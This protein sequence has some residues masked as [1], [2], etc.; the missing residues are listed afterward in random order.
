MSRLVRDDAGFVA[1]GEALL[2]GVLTCVTGMLIA[3]NAWA[4]VDARGQ[5]DT[6]AR[7]AARAFVE[8]DSQSRALQDARS[9]A[10]LSIGDI[11]AGQ[12]LDVVVRSSDGGAA[13]LARC[14]RIQAS[15]TLQVGAIAMPFLGSVGSRTVTGTHS[16]LVDPW[17]S[18][19]PASS[20]V[21]TDCDA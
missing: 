10:A 21:G 18:G 15:V 6:A 17:R 19:L 11:R 7:E 20:L 5:A 4:V 12:V 9:A 2:F 3:V 1:G 14:Q 16:E 8:S 13:T